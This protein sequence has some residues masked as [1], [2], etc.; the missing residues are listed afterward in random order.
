MRGWREAEDAARTSR[1]EDFSRGRKVKKKS[2]KLAK[3][4]AI[5]GII[6]TL[7][8][9][10]KVE[11]KEDTP[12]SYTPAGYGYE[13]VSTDYTVLDYTLDGSIGGQVT[14]DSIINVLQFGDY[15]INTGGMV[16]NSNSLLSG[17]NSTVR[18][19][20]CQITGISV[21][22]RRT[23]RILASAN[24]NNGNVSDE[25]RSAPF[26]DFINN[27]LRDNGLNRQDVAIRFHLGRVRDDYEGIPMRNHGWIDSSQYFDSRC[28]DE[29]IWRRA[30]MSL[31]H[32]EGTIYGFTGDS[33]VINGVT[34]PV[35]GPNGEFL[36]PGTKVVGSNGHE[37][38][39]NSLN[40]KYR[41]HVY[42]FHYKL[43]NLFH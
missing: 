40:Y 36:A 10:A 23:N 28:Y 43:I 14:Q 29:A 27:A 5:T 8:S 42:L 37:Y 34:I 30:L 1:D 24:V 6:A 13:T 41:Q 26:G 22:D 9:G 3:G 21:V 4:L 20:E 16:I 39:I 18:D 17:N 19:G 38:V 35:K 11:W 25:V 2:S 15:C 31:A 33:I 7:L 32:L 12:A